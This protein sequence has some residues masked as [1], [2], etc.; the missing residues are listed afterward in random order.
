MRERKQAMAV[1]LSSLPVWQ[2]AKL[3]W[4]VASYWL[5][6]WMYD[7]SLTPYY[8]KCHRNVKHTPTRSSHARSPRRVASPPRT[9]QVNTASHGL[10]ASATDAPCRACVIR[11]PGASDERSQAHSYEVAHTKVRAYSY[12]VRIS[13]Y[14]IHQMHFNILITSLLCTRTHTVLC[15]A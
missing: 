14:P 3:S 10:A 1:L 9:P 12:C 4:L 7:V 5:A 13:A 8:I 11:Q 15:V 2:L 6:V